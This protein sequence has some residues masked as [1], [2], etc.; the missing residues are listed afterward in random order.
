MMAGGT[1]AALGAGLPNAARAATVT[2]DQAATLKTT[3]TPMG[4]ERAGNADGSI[5]A[6]T[7]G[8][9]EAAPGWTEG[10]PPP[11]YFASDAPVLTINASNVDQ[12][13]DMLAVGAVNLIKKHSDFYI[14]VYPTH[15]TAAAPQWV[16][17]NIYANATSSQLDPRGG[18]FGFNGAYGGIAFPILDP[19][20]AVAGPQVIWNHLTRWDGT[21]SKFCVY[22]Y[23]ITDGHVSLGG[24]YWLKYHFPYYDPNGTVASFNGWYEYIHLDYV[25][26]PVLV[27]QVLMEWSPTNAL[28]SPS[29]AWELLNGQGRVR[30]APEL[31]YDTPTA[32]GGGITNYDESYGFYG[33]PDKYI[34]TYVGK[35]EMYIP[36]NNNA[37]GN[38]DPNQVIGPNFVDP[39]VV[40]YEKHRV[41]VIDAVLAPGER[42]TVPHRRL[43]VDEDNW[44]VAS[45]DLYDAAGN[46]IKFCPQYNTNVPSLPGTLF[47][48]STVYNLQT[49]QYT[50]GTGAF[51]SANYP[52]Y[53]F[54]RQDPKLFNPQDIAAQGQY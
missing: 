7:G 52:G 47:L 2:A 14:K 3:L 11:D 30:K 17:D 19:D 6:W 4:G 26:P 27:G 54:G 43:Y 42:H 39:S 34:W 15:R 40:R 29:Q 13:A 35:K 37:L 5:P 31:T 12:Y 25:A 10:T 50:V 23:I 18:R 20:P 33:A 22:A 46:Y 53:I 8:L 1:A 49:G 24:Q 45:A 32:T 16:Y 9:T 28:V 36:Y 48:N 41:H 21:D 44:H 51:F 38:A